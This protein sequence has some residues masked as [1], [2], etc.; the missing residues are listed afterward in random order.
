MSD[1]VIWEVTVDDHRYRARV[2]RVGSY[3]GVLTVTDL[4]NEVELLRADVGLSYGA[5]FGPDG[6][7][8]LDWQHLALAAIDARRE[9]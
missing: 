3:S 8:V 5:R 9:P 1:D 2:V 7:D 6:S 4:A